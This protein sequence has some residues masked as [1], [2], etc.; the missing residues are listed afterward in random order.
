[1][2]RKKQINDPMEKRGATEREAEPV[3]MREYVGGGAENGGRRVKL[4][5]ASSTYVPMMDVI[6]LFDDLLEW[7][8]E[9]ES[10]RD[11]E[12][13]GEAVAWEAKTESESRLREYGPAKKGND[14]EKEAETMEKAEEEMANSP[15]EDGHRET[16]RAREKENGPA[17]LPARLQKLEEESVCP[18][19]SAATEIYRSEGMLYLR[20]DAV[21]I[22]YLEDGESGMGQTQS[23]I[24][25]PRDRADMIIINR[26]GDVVSSLVCEKGRR[27][28]STYSTPIRPFELCIFTRDCSR[29]IGEDGC[30]SI[31]LD[32]YVEIRGAEAQHTRMRITVK[33]A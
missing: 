31:Y 27:H 3:P 1:M 10:A 24:T 23:E 20:D 30:G 2:E 12:G 25:L 17:H 28:I 26:A 5:M 21:V 9:E 4:V 8:E 18:V 7:E 33:P 19:G 14:G 16:E 13:F 11:P 22:R 29:D 32:Y 6:S 15:Q